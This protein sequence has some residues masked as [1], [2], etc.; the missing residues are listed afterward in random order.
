MR[1]TDAYIT[2]G[3]AARTYTIGNKIGWSP[4]RTW[5][6]AVQHDG[7]KRLCDTCFVFSLLVGFLP[8]WVFTPFGWGAVYV[9]PYSY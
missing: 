4:V 7:R 1:A 6:T 5:G 2:H 9:P 8:V 3:D